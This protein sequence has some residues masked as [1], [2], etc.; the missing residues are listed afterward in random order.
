MVVADTVSTSSMVT[1]SA[2]VNDGG[3]PD[4]IN[5][6]GGGNTGGGGGGGGGGG[7]ISYSVPTTVNFS[8]TAYP[9]SKIYILQNGQ[10]AIT[11][12]ADSAANFSV[13]LSN[14]T[15]GTYNFSI[16]AED[17]KGKKS[18]SFSF[19]IQVTAGTTV[20][21]GNIFLSPT[22]DIDKDEVKQGD[23]VVIFGQSAPKST[24]TISVHSPIES[25]YTT[26]ANNAGS[27]L[28]N[29]NTALLDLG[30]HQAK[31]KAATTDDQLSNFSD[32]VSFV[33]GSQ[34]KTKNDTSCQNQKSDLNC[35]S[36]INLVD[37]SMMA[38]W[39]KHGGTP[40]KNVD[41]NGDG[42]ITLV[43]FSIL[44]YHWTG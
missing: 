19:S 3:G 11:T 41:I 16:Y 32:A 29:L 17:A 15:T 5:T 4:P 23:N 43:D 30:D 12:I 7:N 39:Y 18:S 31:S 37:F 1:I 10:I 14:V 20:N 9:L 21:I 26:V 42:K 33:I 13:A 35:D 34:N 27:Y 2:K 25:F 38:Y 44:A 28:Y 24:V 22:V 6:D 40:P 36:S 8:G